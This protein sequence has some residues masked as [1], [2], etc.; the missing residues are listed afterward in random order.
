MSRSRSFNRFQRFLAKQHRRVL[1]KFRD[2]ETP[3]DVLLSRFKERKTEL[4]G[5]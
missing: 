3:K 1:K 4:Q 5:T 2:T